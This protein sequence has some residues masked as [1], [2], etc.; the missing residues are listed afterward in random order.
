[1]ELIYYIILIIVGIVLVIQANA[2]KKNDGN[3]SSRS[4][5]YLVMGTV[6]IVYTIIEKLPKFIGALINIWPKK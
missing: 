3:Y 2:Q 5:T 4:K 6:F 1:M